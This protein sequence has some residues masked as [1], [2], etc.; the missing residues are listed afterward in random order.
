M[1]KPI[2]LQ[3]YLSMLT[4]SCASSEQALN[5]FREGSL[6]WNQ[7]FQ[8]QAQ[9]LQKLI[10]TKTSEELITQLRTQI[11]DNFAELSDVIDALN[12]FEYKRDLPDV[13]AIW[14]D[15][16]TTLYDYGTGNSYDNT[17]LFVPSLINRSYILD[18][19]KDRSFMRYLAQ[20]NTRPLLLD[21]SDPTPAEMNFGFEK[22]ITSRLDRAIDKV[23][24]I[25]GKPIVL[26][27]Y[28]MGGTM[29]IASALRNQNRLRGL[30]LLATPWD[31]HSEDF[32][33]I[34]L[35]DQ[36]LAMVENALET[37]D[38]V[39][40]STIQSLFYY[41]HSDAVKHKFDNIAAYIKEEKEDL[42][43][44]VAIEN[45]TNDG[46][47]MTKNLARECFID[48]IDQ[49]K[50]FNNQWAI[51]DVVVDPSQIKI[52]TF[53]AS[54]EYDNIVPQSCTAP[55]I[56]MIENVTVINPKSGHVSLVAGSKSKDNLWNPFLNWINGLSGDY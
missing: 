6:N 22:Y 34:K 21:W 42:P 20:N 41:L 17:I 50:T 49:N 13:P 23:T 39:S 32:A 16:S 36:M 8:K 54:G 7:K 18:L 3:T 9:V 26:G 48:W 4:M 33:R 53:F 12:N 2:P 40:A 24:S 5:L 15:G 30:A 35:N 11:S 27:G 45:W 56:D 19:S 25:T 44:L 29:A 31:F 38:I 28:C 51:E 14:Q 46:I 1:L 43:E 47:A 52:P 37:V 10:Q 55:L